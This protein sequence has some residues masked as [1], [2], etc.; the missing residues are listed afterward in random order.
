MTFPASVVNRKLH[1]VQYMTAWKV[2]PVDCFPTKA[3]T[4]FVIEPD[5]CHR[6]H[7]VDRKWCPG[8]PSF[9]E[10]EIPAGQEAFSR[11]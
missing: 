6:L 10:E 8:K 11:N 9:S 7:P 4:S 5:S 2:C 1:Q 3:R